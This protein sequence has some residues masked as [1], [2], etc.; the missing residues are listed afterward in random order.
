MLDFEV[1]IVVAAI[2]GGGVLTASHSGVLSLSERQ[3]L[4]SAMSIVGFWS[5]SVDGAG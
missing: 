3:S 5:W 2:G 1:L 4:I